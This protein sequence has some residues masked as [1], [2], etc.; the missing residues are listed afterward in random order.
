MVAV[1]VAKIISTGVVLMLPLSL[2][3]DD[4]EFDNGGGGRGGSSG[5]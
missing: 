4:C 2:A 5:R 3:M 1:Q